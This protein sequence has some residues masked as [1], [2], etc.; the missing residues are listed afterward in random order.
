MDELFKY[1][2]KIEELLSNID[3]ITQ[4]Q[5]TVLI[6]A[7]TSLQEEDEAIELMNQMVDYKEEIMNELAEIEK[8]F[9]EIYASQ[10][11]NLTNKAIVD[12]LQKRVGGILKRKQL[13]ME[14]EQNNL[15]L[16]KQSMHAR[17][18]PLE[19]KPDAGAVAKAYKK[20]QI[21]S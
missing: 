8:R 17:Q 3:S 7:R 20:H 2:A 12:E 21:K 4:N 19:I 14:C 10:K 11:R 13:I 5:T 1:L 9:Q 16:M 15:I 18:E 6:G